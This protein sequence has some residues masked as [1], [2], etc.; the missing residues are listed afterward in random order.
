MGTLTEFVIKSQGM[1]QL[2]PPNPVTSTE[3][4]KRLL[5]VRD[6]GNPRTPTYKI[7]SYWVGYSYEGQ[8]Q[9]MRLFSMAKKKS[10]KTFTCAVFV[11]STVLF[12]SEDFS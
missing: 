9:S 6:P 11:H 5:H 10:H 2:K 8:L 4:A 3:H 12:P 1:E 7:S